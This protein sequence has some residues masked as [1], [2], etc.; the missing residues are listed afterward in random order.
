MLEFRYS[1]MLTVL[2]VT[3]FY[4]G[5][6]PIMYPVATIFFVLTYWADKCML[7]RCYRRPIKFDAYLARK[8]LEYFKYILILHILGCLLMFGRSPIL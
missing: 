8:T 4:A 5:G 1:N 2:S 7:F 3:F 6:M